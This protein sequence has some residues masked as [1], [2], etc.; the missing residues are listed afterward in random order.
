MHS[1]W[2]DTFLLPMRECFLLLCS[3]SLHCTESRGG[4]AISQDCLPYFPSS[5]A[6]CVS[7]VGCIRPGRYDTSTKPVPCY[8]LFQ[9]AP[10]NIIF[11]LSCALFPLFVSSHDSN[12]LINC[13]FS[14]FPWP[15]CLILYYIHLCSLPLSSPPVILNSWQARPCLVVTL[16]PRRPTPTWARSLVHVGARAKARASA[17][18]GGGGAAEASKMALVIIIIHCLLVLLSSASSHSYS[19]FLSSSCQGHTARVSA[20][21]RMVRV[22]GVRWQTPG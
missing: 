20:E 21:P 6:I 17:G 14:Y 9:S 10:S 1:G 2:P 4:Q 3:P 12:L 19:F 7:S 5:R 22:N 13:L 11:P 8:P 18:W 16:H 15:I